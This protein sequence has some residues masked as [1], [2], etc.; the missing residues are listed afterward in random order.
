MEGIPTITKKH[1]AYCFSTIINSL[2]NK[3]KKPLPYPSG[4]ENYQ[5]PL[6]ITWKF[7]STGNL[8]GCIGTPSLTKGTFAKDDLSKNMGKYA[9]M[10]AFEDSRFDPISLSEV[11]KLSVAPGFPR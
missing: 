6:F 10:A 8:R 4:L 2:K 5:L 9:Q 7:T 11:P 1:L 3:T